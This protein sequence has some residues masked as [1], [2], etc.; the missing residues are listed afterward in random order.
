[1]VDIVDGLH[2]SNKLLQPVH[3][4]ELKAAEELHDLSQV[5][6]L[7]RPVHTIIRLPRVENEVEGDCGD[8]VNN[9]EGPHVAECNPL[10]IVAEVAVIVAARMIEAREEIQNDVDTKTNVNQVL[11]RVGRER[12]KRLC[13]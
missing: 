7:R 4:K 13:C 10:L 8:K 3:T 11:R 5:N 6:E 9:E 12:S 2:L 1:M